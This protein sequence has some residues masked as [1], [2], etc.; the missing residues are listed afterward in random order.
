MC[1]FVV[2]VTTYIADIDTAGVPALGS[3]AAVSGGSVSLAAKVI[4][5]GSQVILITVLR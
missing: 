3:N 1:S 2:K 5:Q 4:V